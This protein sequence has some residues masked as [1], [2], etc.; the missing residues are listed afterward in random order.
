MHAGEAQ[1]E[2][3]LGKVPTRQQQRHTVE[4]IKENYAALINQDLQSD[5][6]PA[7]ASMPT[8]LL[9]KSWA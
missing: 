5:V 7:S 3:R 8:V 4:V 1:T 6:L 9:D 2:T